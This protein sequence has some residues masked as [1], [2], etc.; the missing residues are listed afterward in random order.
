MVR[1]V[2]SFVLLVAILTAACAGSAAQYSNASVTTKALSNN[3]GGS[4]VGFDVEK[5][6]NETWQVTFEGNSVTTEGTAQTYGLYRC[7]VIALENG[8]DGFE[9][10]SDIRL[11]DFEKTYA[12]LPGG[13]PVA[14]TVGAFSGGIVGGFGGAVVGGVLFSQLPPG[15]GGAFPV[16]SSEIKLVKKPFS[17][18]PPKVFD[19]ATLKAALE[20]YVMGKRCEKGN[21]CAHERS[22]LRPAEN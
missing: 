5:L 7:A 1:A 8:Y 11:D 13:P 12:D 20:P 10:L 4:R 9:I 21:V 6:D 3:F 17:G 18:Q 19:A 16:F 15:G 22:Y 14:G 2:P